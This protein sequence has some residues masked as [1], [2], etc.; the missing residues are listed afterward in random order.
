MLD[1]ITVLNLASVGPS[2]RAAQWL[3]DYG[4]RVIQIG[5]IANGRQIEPAF[6]AY[7]ARRGVQR[8][9][10]DLKLESGREVLYR[11]VATSDVLLESFRPQVVNKL[12]IDYTTLSNINPRLVYCSTSGYGQSGP[13][14][15]WAGH[16]INYLALGGFLECTG[17]AADGTPAL[18]GATVADSAG[19]GMQACMSIMAALLQRG[20]SGGGR[21]LDVA[22]IDG[23]LSMMSLYVDQYLATGESVTAGSALLTG[24]YAWYGV[25]PT[26]DSRFVAVGAI[27]P[28]FYSN[29]CAALGLEGFE[30]AQ[31]CDARQPA[32]RDALRDAFSQRDRDEWVA[33]LAH[34]DTCV[35]PVLSVAEATVDP[36]LQARRSVCEVQ[37]AQHGVFK[38]LA[39]LWAGIPRPEQVSLDGRNDSAVIL[40]GAGYSES[41]IVDLLESEAA[42]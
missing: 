27:E 37:H 32:L 1:D 2:A 24:R 13:Y 22:V 25:Y 35:A 18:P 4:A 38:Q 41:Q 29:L 6:H 26:R 39:P 20:S 31:Y 30:E 40:R 28:R 42:E 8:L 7:G 34:R 11:L 12:G 9:N 10:L 3:A 15:Q 16:D 21:Y 5:S 19:G 14:A 36:H 17:R 33:L 23:V